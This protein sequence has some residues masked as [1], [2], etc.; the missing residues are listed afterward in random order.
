MSSPLKA[1]L[2]RLENTGQE[3]S[4]S[5]AFIDTDGNKMFRIGTSKGVVIVPQKKGYDDEVTP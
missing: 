5:E 3:E 4:I 2:D 1:R